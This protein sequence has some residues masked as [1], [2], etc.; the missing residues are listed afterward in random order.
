MSHYPKNFYWVAVIREHNVI[1]Q[2]G[3]CG[4]RQL[5]SRFERLGSD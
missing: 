5:S 1:S 2:L 3:T 4:L